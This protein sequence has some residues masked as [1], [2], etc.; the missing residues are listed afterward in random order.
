M[1]AVSESNKS[2]TRVYSK[3][4]DLTAAPLSLLH[5][6]RLHKPSIVTVLIALI[7]MSEARSAVIGWFKDLFQRYYQ[8][9]EKREEQVKK[10]QRKNYSKRV[11]EREKELRKK[12]K[13]RLPFYW[14]STATDMTERTVRKELEG[15]SC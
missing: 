2:N 14:G 11:R 13:L 12:Q 3:D 6:I 5:L 10:R 1:T 9:P 15:T 8:T 7:F 4:Q